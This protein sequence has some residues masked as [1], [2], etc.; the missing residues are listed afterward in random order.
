M[1][2]PFA[3][4][5]GLLV[6]VT[7]SWLARAELARSEVPL[8]LARP[9]VVAVGFGALVFGPV[10]GYF[11]ARHGDW[12]Y[13]Y[14]IR[15]SRIPSAVDLALVVL[16][17]AQVPLGFALAA[18]WSIAK[19]GSRVLWVAAGLGVALLVASVVAARRLSVSATYAQFHG[20]FGGAPLGK[21]ALGRGVLSSWVALATAYAWAARALRPRGAR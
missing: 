1:P 11:A 14:L 4:P 8:L 18:P 5:L 15:W 16:A 10:V 3:L 6:G 2:L 19:R 21:S 7:L 12:A 13:L 9:F 17:A 20:G